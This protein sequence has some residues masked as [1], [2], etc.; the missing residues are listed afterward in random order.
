[1]E[2]TKHFN[3]AIT[4]KNMFSMVKSTGVR[5]RLLFLFLI[6]LVL[7]FIVKKLLLYELFIRKNLLLYELLARQHNRITLSSYRSRLYESLYES[8]FIGKNLLLHGNER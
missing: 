5:G 1:M 3:E 2:I 6:V 8:L 4:F 7:L